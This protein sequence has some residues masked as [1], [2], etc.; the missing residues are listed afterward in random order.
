MTDEIQNLYLNYSSLIVN[1]LEEILY[2]DLFA[3]IFCVVREFMG[4]RLFKLDFQG[5]MGYKI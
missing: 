2:D 1:K 5:F 3:K 4:F